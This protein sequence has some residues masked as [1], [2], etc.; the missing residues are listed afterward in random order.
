MIPQPPAPE[1]VSDEHLA[2]LISEVGATADLVE[3]QWR[4]VYNALREL[5]QRRSGQ[6]GRPYYVTGL[7]DKHM[8]IGHFPT[9]YA[10]VSY[11][12]VVTVCPWCEQKKP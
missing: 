7:C 6:E 9:M 8:H 12:P 10:N 5:Q 4:G 2:A 1:G 3:G 11:Q